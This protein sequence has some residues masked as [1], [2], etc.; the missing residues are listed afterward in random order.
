[1]IHVLRVGAPHWELQ[2]K[3]EIL[4]SWLQVQMG[5]YGR[6][7]VNHGPCEAGVLDEPDARVHVVRLLREAG[8]QPLEVPGALPVLAAAAAVIDFQGRDIARRHDGDAQGAAHDGQQPLGERFAAEFYDQDGW[9]P[10]E[11]APGECEEGQLGAEDE[12]GVRGV[13]VEVGLLDA[14]HLNHRKEMSEKSQV[15]HMIQN[16]EQDFLVHEETKHRRDRERPKV[17]F[18]QL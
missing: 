3:I 13:E 7:Q 5:E 12:G 16:S 2:K 18:S 8:E 11:D 1:M 9:D 10:D 15:D 6:H 4:S 14:V 17:L